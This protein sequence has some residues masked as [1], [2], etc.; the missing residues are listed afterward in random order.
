[1]QRNECLKLQKM[2]YCR[3]RRTGRRKIRPKRTRTSR[4]I[5]LLLKSRRPLV[6]SYRDRPGYLLLHRQM[7]LK[8]TSSMVRH[9][10]HPTIIGPALCLQRPFEHRFQQRPHLPPHSHIP[11]SSRGNFGP[12]ITLALLHIFLVKVFLQTSVFGSAFSA[13]QSPPTIV[14]FEEIL[15]IPSRERKCSFVIH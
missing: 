13:A 15:V 12:Q 14:S 6:T 11:L 8:G 2:L 4:K 1:M 7:H 3:M 10:C 5:N 9:G